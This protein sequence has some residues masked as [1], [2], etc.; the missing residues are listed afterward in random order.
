MHSYYL[1][2]LPWSSVYCF[3]R[4][5]HWLDIPSRPTTNKL[6]TVADR[7]FQISTSLRPS[8]TQK[9]LPPVILLQEFRSRGPLVWVLPSESPDAIASELDKRIADNRL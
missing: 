2:E 1:G 5:T 7:A 6:V 3:A 9:A 4:I 8:S